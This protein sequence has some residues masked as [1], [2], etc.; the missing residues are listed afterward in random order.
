MGLRVPV[1]VE[2]QLPAA[3][4][5]LT[6]ITQATWNIIFNLK[7]N[8]TNAQLQTTVTYSSEDQLISMFNRIAADQKRK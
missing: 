2:R 4:Q 8:I 3:I 6:L 7:V 1:G 5:M